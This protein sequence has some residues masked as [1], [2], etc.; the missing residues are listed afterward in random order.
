MD[1]AGLSHPALS[2]SSIYRSAAGRADSIGR[3]APFSAYAD[4]DFDGFPAAVADVNAAPT[5][6]Q[7]SPTTHLNTTQAGQQITRTIIIGVRRLVRRWTDHVGFRTSAPTIAVGA[8]M[9]RHFLGVHR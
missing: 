8:R 4:A 5:D 7:G 6:P 9:C 1:Y 2:L 3:R